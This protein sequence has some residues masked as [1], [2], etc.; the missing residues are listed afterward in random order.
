MVFA[1]RST[2]FQDGSAIPTRF[3]QDGEDVSPAVSCSEVPEGTKSLA[4]IVDDPDA[5]DPA[6]PK[7]TFVHWVV[8][9]IPPDAKGLPEGGLPAGAKQGKND[10]GSVGYVGPAPP[11]G[12]HRYFFKLYALDTTLNLNE[13]TKKDLEKAM[14]GHVLAQ[15][16]VMGT[17]QRAGREAA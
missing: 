14:Q 9:D 2:S 3:T 6:A 8:F 16:Q 5:P 11:K 10:A 13:P 15:A 12:K 1:I 4:L 7:T 17:F